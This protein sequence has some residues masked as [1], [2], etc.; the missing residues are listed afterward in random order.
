MRTGPY[1]DQPLLTASPTVNAV[2]RVSSCV[3]LLLYT[4]AVRS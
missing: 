2:V 4:L 1:D 3:Y